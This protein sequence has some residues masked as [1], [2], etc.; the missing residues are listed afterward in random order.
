[1]NIFK[2]QT[3]A[4]SA[5]RRGTNLFQEDHYIEHAYVEHTKYFHWTKSIYTETTNGIKN[6]GHDINHHGSGLR[7]KSAKNINRHGS[8]LR[9]TY[10][11]RR[12]TARDKIPADLNQPVRGK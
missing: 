2:K 9:K 8:E 4:G 3:F 5:L 12:N 10:M 6:I 1:M 11:S 7:I